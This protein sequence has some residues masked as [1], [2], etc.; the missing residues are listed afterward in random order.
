MP[1]IVYIGW[2]THHVAVYKSSRWNARCLVILGY[3]G[4]LGGSGGCVAARNRG[5]RPRKIASSRAANSARP[6]PSREPPVILETFCFRA[7]MPL[8]AHATA[9]CRFC[10]CSLARPPIARDYDAPR[11][12]GS[13]A[14]AKCRDRCTRDAYAAQLASRKLQFGRGCA[15]R[16]MLERR[17]VDRTASD[18]TA[19]CFLGFAYVNAAAICTWNC[20]TRVRETFSRKRKWKRSGPFSGRN[21]YCWNSNSIKIYFFLTHSDL[22]QL[23]L[24]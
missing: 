6:P 12:S 10:C 19:S 8:R 21:S 2:L 5:G 4:M 15:S 13:A 11:A 14:R 9:C 17:K 1:K 22:G 16:L 18:W 23:Q 24:F 3:L 20:K 7:R